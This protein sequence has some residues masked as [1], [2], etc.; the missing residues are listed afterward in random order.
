MTMN[1]RMSRL[2]LGLCATTLLAVP[3][4]G[5]DGATGQNDSAD[6]A[7]ETAG[8]SSESVG[9]E[10]NDAT[11]SGGDE[12][13]GNDTV[14]T[15]T[16][17]ETGVP[18]TGEA[19]EE[20]TTTTE[21]EEEESG[22]T[23]EIDPL[24]EIPEEEWEPTENPD[25]LPGIIPGV[26]D[27]EGPAP[28]D[29]GFRSLIGF[30]LRNTNDLLDKIKEIYDP[31]G[32]KF[33]EFVEFNE[34]MAEHAPF[35]DDFELIKAWLEF[36]G[37]DVNFEAT[38]RLLIQFSGTVG[39]FNDVF[40]TELHI[41]MRKN[42]QVGNP[43][44]P[45]YCT[46]ESFTLPIFVADRTKG[47]VTADLPAE[48]GELPAEIGE[49][50]NNPPNSPW[51]FDPNEIAHAYGVDELFDQG[52]DG[53]GSKLCVT[54]GATFRYK[55]LQTFWQSFGVE[56]D[57]PTVI[58]LMEPVVTRYIETQLDT[59]WSGGLAPGATMRVY[60]GPDSRNTSMVFVFNETISL[61]WCDIITDSFA[62][63]EDSEPKLVR[64]QYDIAAMVGAALGQ[65]IVAASGDSAKP[66]TPSASTYVTAVG[67]T[68]LF[69]NGLNVTNEI[70]WDR[71]GSG[72][73]KSFA[74]PWYQEDWVD[75]SNGKRAVV[76]VS[77]AA[78]PWSPYWVR[79]LGEWKLYGGTSFSAPVFAGLL[80]VVNEYRADMGVPRLGFLNPILYGDSE[81][82]GTFRDITQGATQYFPAGPGW[83]YPTGWGAPH[84][85]DFAQTYPE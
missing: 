46:L 18:D 30:D 2:F 65:T 34:I 6:A 73:T 84:G 58:E 59:E 72:I 63:R 42:P 1:T 71:S 5:D 9:D 68:R 29:D 51:G 22:E 67:G 16:S 43:P 25:G 48:T 37:F 17:E 56:R 69:M 21:E 13:E 27:D 15:D 54:A 28:L 85:W 61:N 50:T 81:V 12:S 14:E 20:D 76:D 53:T 75:D 78:S 11:A 80:A 26:Y 44:I 82:R 70:A 47:I 49:I 23:G 79:Y 7:D 64:E 66:D 31:D 60:E 55:D 32:D 36:E 38:N 8:E 62:H 74:L 3:A 77:L 39:Q 24:D 35:E 10:G 40:N 45:V 33:L 52:Y 41:C 19:E 83:D 57:N 4:C